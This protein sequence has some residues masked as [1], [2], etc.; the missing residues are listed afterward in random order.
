MACADDLH[1]GTGH[2]SMDQVNEGRGSVLR[3]RREHWLIYAARGFAKTG[4]FRVRAG[5]SELWRAYPQLGP[6]LIHQSASGGV[7]ILYFGWRHDRY[8]TSVFFDRG[9]VMSLIRE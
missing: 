5:V 3:Y 4:G 6:K 2:S 9:W 1:Q 8:L 7:P